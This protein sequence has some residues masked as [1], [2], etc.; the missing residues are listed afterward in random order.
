MSLKD[1]NTK[2]EVL[3][4]T[5]GAEGLNRVA[6]MTMPQVEGVR[7]LVSCQSKPLP[8]PKELADRE[9]IAVRFCNTKGVA[10]NR[11]ANLDAASA[12]YVLLSDD[13]LHYTPEALSFVIDYM[14]NHPEISA[15]C[16]R[17]SGSDTPRYPLQEKELSTK[18]L[19]THY[20]VS[21]EIALRLKDVRCKNLRFCTL[22]GIGAPYLEAGEETLFIYCLL[23]SGLRARFIPYTIVHHERLTTGYRRHT[24]GV[25]R[26]RGALLRLWHPWTSPLRMMRLARS[27]EGSTMGNLRDLAQGWI[28]ACRNRQQLLNP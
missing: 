10:A 15:A 6:Q 25:L 13:D 3:V 4:C 8:L 20:P 22:T 28:F 9:D 26:A 24:P 27:L 18:G 17:Y 12:P 21:F 7:W 2:L 16:F 1:N 23:K 19:N 14:E 5:H 11:S